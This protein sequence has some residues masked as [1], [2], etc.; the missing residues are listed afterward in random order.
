MLLVDLSHIYSQTTLCATPDAESY[1]GYVHLPPRADDAS[2]HP[3][4]M[5]FYYA[6]SSKGTKAPLTLFFSGGP[7]AS[8]ISSMVTE[9]G[10][11]WIQSDSNSTSPNPWSWT[12]ESDMLFVDQPTLTGYSYDVLT[13]T[14][15]DYTTSIITPADFSDGVPE[16]NNTFGV[17]VFGSQ[18]L[19]G[20]VNSTMNG[21]KEMWDFMQ[22]WLN[23]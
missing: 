17:G 7:G 23:E 19:N 10:D 9:M 11:C 13:N 3:N 21:A 16:A 1:S 6:K 12:R 2:P 15:I 18:N 5:Y 4:N 8:S 14:T 20:T 22:V